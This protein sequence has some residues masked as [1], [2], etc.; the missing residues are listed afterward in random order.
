MANNIQRFLF[1][2][3]KYNLSR[4]TTCPKIVA[5][6]VWS[7]LPIF[8]VTN[9]LF[10][11]GRCFHCDTLTI[12]TNIS[13]HIFD[14]HLQFN[15]FAFF[16]I[17]LCF[18]YFSCFHLTSFIF[19]SIKFLVYGTIHTSILSFQRNMIFHKSFTHYLIYIRFCQLYICYTHIQQNIYCIIQL[20][21]HHKQNL[22]HTVIFVFKFIVTN[23][24]Q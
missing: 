20:K 6:I 19:L 3:L 5:L 11:L 8:N 12:A 14:T 17:F 16:I 21:I 1:Y 7:W 2:K 15:A 9:H 18:I 4:Y 13:N 10:V 22:Y 24:L 23:E